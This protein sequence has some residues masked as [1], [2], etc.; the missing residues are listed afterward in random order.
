MGKMRCLMLILAVA[1]VAAGAAALPEKEPL[2]VFQL[3]PETAPGAD[4]EPDCPVELPMVLRGTGLI[5]QLLTSYEGPFLEREDGEPVTG[6]AALM[7]CNPGKDGVEA[8]EVALTQGG[9]TL[10]FYFSWLPPESRILVLEKNGRPYSREP[11]SDCRCLFLR[12]GPVEVC[13]GV[14]L[15]VSGGALTLENRTGGR[16]NRVTVRY[17]PYDEE[18]GFFLGGAARWAET[19]PLEAGETVTLRPWGFVPGYCRIAAVEAE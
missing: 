1:A 7:I 16:L 4:T 2:A 14:A 15:T 19:G 5:V 6:A 3:P 18:G 12:R 13:P 8:A 10:V 11:I 9:D 17:K